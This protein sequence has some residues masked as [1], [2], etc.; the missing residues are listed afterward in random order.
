MSVRVLGLKSILARGQKDMGGKSVPVFARDLTESMFY[1]GPL[2][3]FNTYTTRARQVAKD[4][5]APDSA[6]GTPD[7]FSGS[8][9]KKARPSGSSDWFDKEGED[10]GSVPQRETTDYFG[11]HDRSNPKPSSP[12]PD[13]L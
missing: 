12:P 11:E 9:P 1:R 2:K 6:P 5:Y 8:A 7:Y 4:F 3:R 10:R 13:W